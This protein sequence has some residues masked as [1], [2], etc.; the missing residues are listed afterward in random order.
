M[1][2]ANQLM[3]QALKSCPKCNKLTQTG[4]TVQEP[5]VLLI[6]IGKSA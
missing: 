6:R 1:I 3:P 2:W 4:H 5:L